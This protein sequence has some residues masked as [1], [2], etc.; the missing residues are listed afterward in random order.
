MKGS[1]IDVLRNS[2][3]RPNQPLNNNITFI[4]T[5]FG[6]IRLLDTGGNK[7]VIINAPDGPN[8]IEHQKDLISELSKEFRVVCFEFPGTGFSYPSFK[9][10][11]SIESGAKLLIIL[12]DLLK[13][14]KAAFLFSCS[15]GLYGI[16]ATEM[17]SSRVSYLFL[18]QTCSLDSFDLW[19]KK[20]IPNFLKYPY[21]GQIANLLLLK[22]LTK[23]WYQ[24]SLPKSFEKSK[25]EDTALAVIKT[26][27]CFCLASLAQ[28]L[29][30]ER[31]S[32]LLVDEVP[33]L[34]FWGK[35]DFT[36]RKT[37]SHSIVQHLPNCEV[38][39]L[40]DCGHFPEL[41]NTNK[42]AKLIMDRMT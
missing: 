42:C 15:N 22:K 5:V 20:S 16:K 11:Y 30:K 40:L 18:S 7:D 13:V 26:G 23:L 41:E 39:E 38:I 34:L 25:F 17:D 3:K 19:S 9:Y 31:N 27:G 37:S 35:K 33:A 28:A 2:F 1:K 21:V 36:H 8:V 32:E 14:K 6:K 29:R 24:Y 4:D 10:D 12:M